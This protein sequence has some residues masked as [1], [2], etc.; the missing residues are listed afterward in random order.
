MQSLFELLG[1][2]VLCVETGKQ[3]GEV[4][5]ALLSVRDAA[6]DG[7][8]VSGKAWLAEKKLLPFAQLHRIGP[9]AVTVRSEEALLPWSE[10]YASQKKLYGAK[11]LRGK[12]LDS[13]AGVH[14]GVLADIVFD[15][16]TGEIRSYLVS[17]GLVSDILYG[18][19][20]M[21]LPQAQVVCEDRIIIPES[22][23]KL[24]RYT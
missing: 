2:P 22:M 8:M 16:R 6:L 14:L 24:L 7:L 9:D 19:A 17:D 4:E 20:E 23:E 11:E 1:L 21:P 3:V 18:R 13:E 15:S 5:E 12:R 10:G